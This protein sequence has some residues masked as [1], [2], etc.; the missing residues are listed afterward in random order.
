MIKLFFPILFYFFG[1]I[2]FFSFTFSAS[3]MCVNL[4]ICYNL[5]TSV[6]YILFIFVCVIFY[7]N[8]LIERRFVKKAN[9]FVRSIWMIMA[10]GWTSWIV[11]GNIIPF[12]NNNNPMIWIMEEVRLCWCCYNHHKLSQAVLNYGTEYSPSNPNGSTRDSS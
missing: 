5:V 3:L 4:W 1:Y 9:V 2:L 7:Y 10:L 8:V 6:F 11:D 12:E